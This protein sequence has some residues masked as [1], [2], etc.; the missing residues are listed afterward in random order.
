MTSLEQIAPTECSQ[1]YRCYRVREYQADSDGYECCDE[2]YHGLVEVQS[3]QEKDD[4]ELDDDYH[5]EHG[6]IEDLNRVHGSRWIC[7]IGRLSEDKGG[8]QSDSVNLLSTLLDKLH[9]YAVCGVQI[10]QRLCVGTGFS[11]PCVVVLL[12]DDKHAPSGLHH[13]VDH[14]ALPLLQLLHRL[15][16]VVHHVSK[17]TVEVESDEED[18]ETTEETRYLIN[19]TEIGTTD[20]NSF[21]NL[22]TSMTWQSQDENAQPSGEADISINFYKEGGTNVTVD[23]YSYD[24]NFY[25][26]IDSKGNHMLVNKMDVREFLDAFDSAMEELNS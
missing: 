12:L 10:D 13:Q 17:E 22:I 23:Y 15:Q 26:A 19:D 24:A 6:T 7:G 18:G 14:P 11:I 4:S 20:F 3:Q 25:L 16:G 21:Y 2:S 8:R 1:C 5:D 9:I